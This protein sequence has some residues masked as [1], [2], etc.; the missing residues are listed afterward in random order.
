[1]GTKTARAALLPVAVMFFAVL[2]LDIAVPTLVLSIMALSIWL[3]TFDL[4]I[5]NEH[6]GET[7]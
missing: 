7:A 4:T 1:M 2:A 5:A 3:V 6:E